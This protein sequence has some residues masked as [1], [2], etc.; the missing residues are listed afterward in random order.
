MRFIFA[1][2]IACLLIVG[3]ISA[4]GPKNVIGIQPL[5]LASFANIEFEHAFAPK[6]SFAFRVDVLY[7]KI[8]DFSATGFGGGG[9]LRFYP[10]ASAPKRAYGGLDI[11][12]VHVSA[13]EEDTEEEGSATFFAIGAVIGWKWLIADALAISLD[14]G[15]MYYAGSL[16]VGESDV[17]LA[18]L[19]PKAD[20]YIG[21]AF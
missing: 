5:S 18:G 10:L 21:L 1:V 13:K 8:E 3:G 12:I 7:R 17:G 11:D 15:P 14:I 4:G 6:T 16:E 2:S 9:S 20:F 19:G